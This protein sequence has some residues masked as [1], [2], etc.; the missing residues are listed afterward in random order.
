MR[1]GAALVLGLS[2]A[3]ASKPARAFEGTL[4]FQSTNLKGQSHSFDYSI[5]D[6][7]VRIDMDTPKM[8]R[9]SVIVD[10]STQKSLVLIAAQKSY[11]ER[12]ARD[13]RKA[14]GAA[15]SLKKT[16]VVQN[17][18]GYSCEQMIA[19]GPEGKTEL[20]AAKG[21][22]RFLQFLGG[23]MGGRPKQNAW[24]AEF[25][26]QGYFPLKIVGPTATVEAVSIE[27][28]PLPD[29]FFAV[30]PGYQKTDLGSLLRAGGH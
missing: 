2:L 16:G 14:V 18:L 12:E 23:P 26:S 10:A 15:F 20:W 25:T 22:G 6:R 19:T 21:L 1:L 4:A 7:L 3:L 28:K 11:L 24:E 13:P 9:L 5:K 29:S 8:G 17:I 30:P 27:A